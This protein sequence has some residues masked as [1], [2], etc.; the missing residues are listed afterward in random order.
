MYVYIYIY[1]YICVPRFKTELW[2]LCHFDTKET[3]V[4][5][6]SIYWFVRFCVAVFAGGGRARHVKATE[7]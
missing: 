5:T 6:P 3:F 7:P 4:L 2:D 1:M